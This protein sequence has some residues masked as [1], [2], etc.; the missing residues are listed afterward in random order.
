MSEVLVLKGGN[1]EEYRES[2][3]IVNRNARRLKQLTEDIFDVTRIE[4]H[5]LYLKREQFKINDVIKDA[6]QDF[7][8]QVKGAKISG[9]KTSILFEPREDMIIVEADKGRI[10]QVISNLLGNAI[11]FTDGEGTVSIIWRKKIIRQ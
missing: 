9:S 10:S 8:S 2:L 6:V 5:T 7:R 1:I 3:D 11:K 4:S